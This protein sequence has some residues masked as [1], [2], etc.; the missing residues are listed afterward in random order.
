MQDM[1][2]VAKAAGIALTIAAPAENLDA[3]TEAF[4]AMAKDPPDALYVIE[5]PFAYANA[6]AIGDLAL[7]HRIPTITGGVVHWRSRRRPAGHLDGYGVDDD[8]M[9]R[10]AGYIDRILRGAK[11]A[12]LPVQQSTKFSLIVNAVTARALGLTV[13]QSILLRANQV[14]E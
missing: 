10:A 14:I 7:A 12:D 11:P 9:R 2:E 1:E 6:R 4:A 5:S 8:S 13:P 3:L